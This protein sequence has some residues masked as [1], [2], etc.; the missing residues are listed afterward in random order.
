[1]TLDNRIPQVKPLNP[2]KGDVQKM[3]SYNDIYKRDNNPEWARE[4]IVLYAL[5]HGVKPTARKFKC[6]KNTVKL[7]LSRKDL[8]E[9]SRY[10]NKSKKPNNSPKKTSAAIENQIVECR[11]DKGMGANNLKHQYDI[12]VSPTTVYN[13]LL[14][15][16]ADLGEDRVKPKKKKYQI[17]QDLRAVKEKLKAFQSIQ[18]DGKVL[19]D[20]PE[21]YSDYQKYNIPRLQWTIRCQ[22]TGAAFISYSKGETMVSA[23]TFLVYFFEHLKRHTNTNIKRLKI[24]LKTDWGSYAIGT[25]KS[26]KESE[27]KTF[28]KQHYGINHVLIKHKNS[29]SE[30]ERFHGLVE[31]Y[32]YKRI[33][34]NSREDLFGKATEFI[35]WFNY[36]RKN[37]YRG[38]RTPLEI[39]E[40][41]KRK[42]DP[43]I[44]ALPAI[45]LDK[46]QDIYWY[47]KDPNYKPLTE[48]VFFQDSL[49]YLG[50]LGYL[51]KPSGGQHVSELDGPPVLKIESF[52]VSLRY[53]LTLSPATGDDCVLQNN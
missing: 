31:D 19:Y 2:T 13:V 47:K 37:G 24:K 11:K 44:L 51:T 21:F 16:A 6:H 52:L 8:P 49:D 43:Q 17:K 38:W 45:D 14:R 34:L 30:V 53:I 50:K 39:L 41:D 25:K 5:K 46:H 7:W 42:F 9:E 40:K 3:Y 10:S 12:P 1:M 27:F 15:R 4:K 33:K 18:I 32:F 29:N 23:L 26:F 22:K 48:D 20:I 36:I 28:L 35:V